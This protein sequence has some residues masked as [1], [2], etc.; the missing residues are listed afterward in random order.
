MLFILNR[1]RREKLKLFQD[2]LQGQGLIWVLEVKFL[3]NRL[4]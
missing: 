1:N 3:Q 2:S 4:R